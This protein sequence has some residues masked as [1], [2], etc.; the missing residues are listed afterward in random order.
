MA[1]LM[2]RPIANLSFRAR[3]LAA[4]ALTVIPIALLSIPTPAGAAGCT[5]HKTCKS[6][7]S[8]TVRLS[9]PASGSSVAG[10]VTVSGSGATSWSWSWNTTS[11]TNGIHTIGAQATDTSGNLSNVATESINVS[12]PTPDST[13]PT[14][15][16]AS[17]APGATVSG[18]TSVTGTASDNAAVA[19]VQVAVDGGTW[20]TASGTASW[21]WSWNTTSLT[22]GSHTLAARA[23]DASGN[24]SNVATES[25]TVSNS[26]VAPDA[27]GSWVSP[28]G[29]HINVN[30]AGPWTIN[31]IY[32]L[33]QANALELSTIGPTYT[34]DVQDQYSSMTT[35]MVQGSA[36]TYSH[37]Q[38]TTYLLGVNST[39]ASWPDY[40][41][42]H[43]YG[44]VW[45]Q[46]H[47]FITHQ[48]DWSPYLGAR[49][50]GSTYNGTAYQYLGQDTRLYS[51]QTWQPAEIIADDY[52]LLFGSSAAISERPN[53]INTT[54]TDPRN[55]PGL[56]TFLLQQWA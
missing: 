22:N 2:A 38:A 52:R 34:I 35:T 49:S 8:P 33:L 53:N 54:I 18:T 17:P 24:L 46:Y 48:G 55:Q 1:A 20:Q 11:L 3:I 36:G 5:S 10:T 41:L 50:D 23:N 7:T 13:P 31:Q 28:E 51:S 44:E 4:S 43:E 30:S 32:S 14:A 47:L 15:V 12:N 9:S 42:T 29:V 21:S 40:V 16:I 25:V 37:F 56:G 45:S 6:S 39:F 27:Q 19:T 26:T